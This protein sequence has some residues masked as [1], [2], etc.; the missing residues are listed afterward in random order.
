MILGIIQAIKSRILPSK[1]NVLFPKY[2]HV[3]MSKP[4][5][6]HIGERV[7]FGTDVILSADSPISIGHDTMIANRVII[8]TA[9]HDYHNNPMWRERI[10]R[11]IYIG[12]H[13][14]IGTGAIILPG[15]KIHDYSVIGA[16]SVVTAHVP[17]RVIVA[18][19]PARIIKIREIITNDDLVEYPGYAKYEGYLPD[20]NS[21]KRVETEGRK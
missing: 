8:N 16:G 4:E 15:V 20:T 7:S 14:W 9:T 19:N 1:E 17:K 10:S 13:V 11:P 2:T 5:N 18:G 21:V 6:I 3:S 12:N